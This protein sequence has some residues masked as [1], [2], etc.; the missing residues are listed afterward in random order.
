V[1]VVA[2]DKPFVEEIKVEDKAE[3]EDEEWGDTIQ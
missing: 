2:K 3:E 1:A